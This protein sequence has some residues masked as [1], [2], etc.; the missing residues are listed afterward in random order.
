MDQDD[1]AL[2]P[3]IQTENPSSPVTISF[4]RR[5]V[6]MYYVFDQELEMIGS[7][8]TQS[9][10]HLTFFGAAFGAALALWITI[11]TI[12]ITGVTKAAS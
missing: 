12:E 7:A 8:S 2:G 1:K 4:K 3:V 6:A 11:F 9:S 5:D 10:L